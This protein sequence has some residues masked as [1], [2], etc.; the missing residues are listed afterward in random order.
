MQSKPG[1][2]FGT[3]GQ[4]AAVAKAQLK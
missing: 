2:W 1:V 4:V 3:L